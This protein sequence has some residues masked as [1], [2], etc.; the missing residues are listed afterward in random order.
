MLRPEKKFY[1]HP[2]LPA[3]VIVVLT[4]LLAVPTTIVLTARADAIPI[5][6][7]PVNLGPVVN[8]S[9]YAYE[10][11]PHI[12][13]DELEL[14]FLLEWERPDGSWYDDIWV[15][16]RKAKDKPWGPPVNLGPLVNTGSF[17]G[18]PCLSA[19]GLEL[20]FVSDRPSGSGSTDIFVT[21]RKSK[22]SLWGPPVNLGP[23]VNSTAAENGPSISADGLELYFSDAIWS[24]PPPR[25]GGMGGADIWVTKRESKNKPW[26]PPLNLGPTVNSSVGDVAPSI[27][28]DGLSLYFVSKRPGGFGDMDIWVTTRKTKNSPWYT[29]INLGPTVNSSGMENNPDISSD[30]STLYFVSGRPGNVGRDGYVDIWQVS[31]KSHGP[32]E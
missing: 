4:A 20:Y 22:D 8:S 2:S 10:W 17:E 29:P 5:F 24:S 3:A 1:K 27:S 12:S 16:T 7:D 14:Y 18:A 19:E 31:L 23:K 26:G 21:K 30:G 15:T 25:P 6:G 9:A 28:T 11:D 32:K 13:P